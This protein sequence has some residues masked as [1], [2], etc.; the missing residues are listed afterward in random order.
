MH[1][2]NNIIHD[3]QIPAWALA[4]LVNGELDGYTD[5][6]I[7]TMQN[8]EREI[9]AA[10]VSPEENFEEHFSAWPEFGSLP[11]AVVSCDV[12]QNAYFA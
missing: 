6:E 5:E 10:I 2:P 7:L 11:C 1:N 4:Y 12:V 9:D 3:V 8:W